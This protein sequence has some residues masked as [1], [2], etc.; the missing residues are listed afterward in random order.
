MAQRIEGDSARFRN[1][2]RG[3]IKEQLKGYI[4]QGEMVGKKGRDLVSIHCRRFRC[5]NSAMDES[6]P[7]ALA[8]GQAT[9]EI[10]SEVDNPEKAAPDKAR[11][12]TFWK[13]MF[14]WMNWRNCWAKSWN[15]RAST[16]RREKHLAGSR[17]IHRHFTV[18]PNSLRHFQAHLQA[19]VAAPGVER[20]IQRARPKIVPV[21]EDTR[22]RR[23]NPVL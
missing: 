23:W 20:R 2:V 17:Q 14:R 9:S 19:G 13:S 8:K 7:A 3:K 11:V 10:R 21:R 6:K 22:Y 12:S 5:L 4:S 15:C 1:I 18:G 16:A